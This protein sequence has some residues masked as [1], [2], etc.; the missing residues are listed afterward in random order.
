MAFIEYALKIIEVFRL[1]VV[2]VIAGRI[3]IIL[4]YADSFDML[5]LFAIAVDGNNNR[6]NSHIA[7]CHLEWKRHLRPE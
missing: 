5:S 2:A 6:I 3:G 1:A 4:L 7:C